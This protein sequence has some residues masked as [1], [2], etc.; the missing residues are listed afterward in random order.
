MAQSGKFGAVGGKARVHGHVLA[1]KGNDGQTGN[2][3]VCTN[4]DLL[5]SRTRLSGDI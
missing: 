5:P 4:H 3:P 2:V 1:T